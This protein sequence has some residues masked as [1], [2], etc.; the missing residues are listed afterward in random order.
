LPRSIWNGTIA[1][2][3][4]KVPVKQPPAAASWANAT[5]PARIAGNGQLG[6]EP[7]VAERDL[8]ERLGYTPHG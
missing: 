6:R 1:F 2:G 8:N 4:V 3:L 5:T 7:D